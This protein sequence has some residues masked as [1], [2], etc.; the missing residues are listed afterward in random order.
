MVRAKKPALNYATHLLPDV[1]VGEEAAQFSLG[2]GPSMVW[3]TIPRQHLD[4]HGL[5]LT[6]IQCAGIKETF[7]KF[8]QFNSN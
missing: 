3:V 5:D 4:P 7:R 6:G 1:V 2:E 8:S